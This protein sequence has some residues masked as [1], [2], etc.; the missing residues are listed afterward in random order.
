ML[1]W[2]ADVSKLTKPSDYRGLFTSSLSAKF[3]LNSFLNVECAD[4]ICHSLEWLLMLLINFSNIHLC[5]N[6]LKFRIFYSWFC[7]TQKNE[8]LQKE[9]FLFLL[10]LCILLTEFLLLNSVFF[11]CSILLVSFSLYYLSFLFFSLYF[12]NLDG[13]S[14]IVCPFMVTVGSAYSF[15]TL[16]YCRVQVT[17]TNT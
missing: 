10:Q 12:F 6:K 16:Q 8:F 1:K 13:P 11:N 7:L 15:N 2:R 4:V 5:W 17:G 9:L 14:L 3:V